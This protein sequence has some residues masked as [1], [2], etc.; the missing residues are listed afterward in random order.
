MDCDIYEIHKT[1]RSLVGQWF[2]K[3]EKILKI[4][5]W[6]FP[7]LHDLWPMCATRYTIVPSFTPS[8]QKKYFRSIPVGLKRL[9]QTTRLRYPPPPPPRSHNG[10]TTDLLLGFQRASEIVRRHG[11]FGRQTRRAEPRVE[12]IVGRHRDGEAVGMQRLDGQQFSVA[13]ATVWS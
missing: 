6:P 12:M 10:G 1:D 3:S 9:P 5:L 11:P 4:L 7:P 2:S 8:C 13:G